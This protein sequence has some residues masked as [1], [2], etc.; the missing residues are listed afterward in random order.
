MRDKISKAR[1]TVAAAVAVAQ[2]EPP[3][4]R[5]QEAG[6]GWAGVGWGGVGWASLRDPRR[7]GGRG[8]GTAPGQAPLSPVPTAVPQGLSH[9]VS[10]PA[11]LSPPQ[12]P[13]P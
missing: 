2:E 3:L 4:A 10:A 1:R 11:L 12:A 13:C 5:G 6:L 9:C 8:P 7:G